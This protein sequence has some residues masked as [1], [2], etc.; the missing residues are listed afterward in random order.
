MKEESE[1][2]ALDQARVLGFR[3]RIKS[4]AALPAPNPGE[5]GDPKTLI[6]FD[7]FIQ[8]G[9]TA[10]GSTLM[11][12]AVKAHFY[13]KLIGEGVEQGR[14]LEIYAQRLKV[15]AVGPLAGQTLKLLRRFGLERLI[16]P[17]SF[18]YLCDSPE[19]LLRYRNLDERY[20]EHF[21]GLVSIIGELALGK[22]SENIRLADIA[23][24][25]PISTEWVDT[26]LAS[27]DKVTNQE[28]EAVFHE[29]HLLLN[30]I[31]HE[32]R[33][34]FD[35]NAEDVEF[36][37]KIR[38]CREAALLAKWLSEFKRGAYGKVMPGDEQPDM[39]F[40]PTN[41]DKQENDTRYFFP[42]M[43][44]MELFR[45]PANKQLFQ[46]MDY[47]FS[48]FLE[49]HLAL[50]IH[51]ARESGELEPGPEHLNTYFQEKSGELKGELDDL[52][53]MLGGIDDTGSEVY[54]RML[55]M[56]E[57]T[58][59]QRYEKFQQDRLKAEQELVEIAH[60]LDGLVEKLR[61]HLDRAGATAVEQ[62]H[63]E[64]R[65]PG[66][67]EQRV[68]DSA[69][70]AEGRYVERLDNRFGRLR[71]VIEGW[72]AMLQDVGATLAEINRLDTLRQE[73]QD[74]KQIAGLIP[75]W[76]ARKS[77]RLE[78]LRRMNPMERDHHAKRVEVQVNNY[79]GE[80]QQVDRRLAEFNQKH[81]SAVTMLG[82]YVAHAARRLEALGELDATD[83]PRQVVR[84][85]ELLRRTL[86]EISRNALRLAAR[87]HQLQENLDKMRLRRHRDLEQCHHFQIELA[88]LQAVASGAADP[89]SPFADRQAPSAGPGDPEA[90][91][92]E[93]AAQRSHLSGL[94]REVRTAAK[95]VETALQEVKGNAA[96]LLRFKTLREMLIRTVARK[97]R[98]RESAQALAERQ[99]IMDQEL[100]DLPQR[101]KNLF[102]PARK[103]L[104]LEVF[105]PEQERRVGNIVKVQSFMN[106]LIGLSHERLKERYL[107]HAILR[108][109][110]SR[111]FLRG[112]AYA[113][114]QASALHHAMRNVAPGLK[115]LQR[116]IVHNLKNHSLPGAERVSLPQLTH[117]SPRQI[118]EAL[119]NMAGVE[120]P[121]QFNYLVLPPT[122]SLTEGLTIIN[123]K[124]QLFQGVPRL[125]LIYVGKFDRRLIRDDA[126]IREA[127]FKAVQHN[128]VLNIDGHVVV[129]N[130]RPIGM[131]LLADTLGCAI[132]VPAV[133]EP[134][135]MG[136]AGGAA[137]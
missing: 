19:E 80:T 62:F 97:R 53:T 101:V 57:A 132:D 107:D 70:E 38:S 28:L 61:P 49:E 134:P 30:F 63:Q 95:S 133:E 68:L 44:C 125:V 64:S 129:D 99:S 121:L 47:D 103:K 41:E 3:K 71:Q 7:R 128:V 126:A 32:F 52:N 117:H 83:D 10:G 86:G 102:M 35:I 15:G 131:R 46:E 54:Q 106:D 21:Q 5:A 137:V 33:R 12:E 67:A 50:A 39:L 1:R 16:D 34:N 60:R 23:F 20:E 9:G 87:S 89:V 17:E 36:F 51:H 65:Q 59:H 91:G 66:L 27:F 123:K 98:V 79:K 4:R 84:Q 75:Q 93:W 69:E 31:T 119:E 37:S 42:G 45:E 76:E 122:L 82:H 135:G 120:G 14:K 48:V 105:V 127:Y 56:E 90:I 110:Y 136:S 81:N 2:V 108:R 113:A 26:G 92:R 111:Q 40:F 124:D 112:G 22:P 43:S 130:P 116:A 11:Q 74:R 6:T 55:K 114:D 24:N 25:M 96:T 118:L 72:V 58:F 18:Y 104:L 29:M 88:L 13:R 115:L 77:E 78:V 8:P 109:F 73:A 94:G 100:A 85:A